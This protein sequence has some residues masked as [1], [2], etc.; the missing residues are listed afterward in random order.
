MMQ[1]HDGIIEL[2]IINARESEHMRRFL[3]ERG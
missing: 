2:A 1:K 3:D